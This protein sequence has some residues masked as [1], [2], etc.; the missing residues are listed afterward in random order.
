MRNPGEARRAL[1]GLLRMAHAG[2]RAAALAYRGH[3]RATADP[4]ERAGI[5]RIEHDEWDH[6]AALRSMLARLG[7]RPAWWRELRALV[8]GT[9]LGVLCHIAGRTLPLRAAGWLELRNT[10]EYDRAAALARAAG[11]LEMVVPLLHMSAVEAEHA[12]WFAA[13]LAPETTNR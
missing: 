5:R 1:I 12:R 9:V 13:A 11:R 6:R 7:A 8:I 4:G 3:W 2:E 10:G